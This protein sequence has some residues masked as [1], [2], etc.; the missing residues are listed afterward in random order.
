MEESETLPYRLLLLLSFL[1]LFPI[2][3]KEAVH[4][5]ETFGSL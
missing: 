4:S 3:K 1:A 5:S 2:Q